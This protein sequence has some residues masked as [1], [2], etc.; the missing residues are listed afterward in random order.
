MAVAVKNTP[1]NK[2]RTPLGSLATASILG[3]AYV[4]GCAAVLFWGVPRV[5]ELGVAPYLVNLSFVSVAGLIVVEVVAVIMLSLL[6]TALVGPAPPRG[7]RAGVFAVLVWVIT[8]G[9]LTLLAGR[10]FE[11]WFSG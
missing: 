4:L 6:G 9:L 11:S 10:A 2:T 5:W 7:M 1:E 3:A 8:A